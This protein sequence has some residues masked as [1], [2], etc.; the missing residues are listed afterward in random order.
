VVALCILGGAVG[1]AAGVG[2]AVVLRNSFGWSTTV[3]PSSMVL[4]FLFAASVGILFGVSPARRASSLD[5]IEALRY[6]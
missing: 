5:L 2:L 4:A 3:G 1:I 6:E